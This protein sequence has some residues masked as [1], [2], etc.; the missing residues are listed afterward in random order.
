MD[1]FLL[2]GIIAFWVAVAFIVISTVTAL[3]L[4]WSRVRRTAPMR[5]TIEWHKNPPRR[6]AS[7][8]PQE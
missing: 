4:R 8:T 5:T 3:A 2:F 7:D 6:S 1:D